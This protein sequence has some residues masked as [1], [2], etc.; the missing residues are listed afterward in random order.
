MSKNLNQSAWEILF[1]RYKI[2]KEIEKNGI[3]YISANQIKKER[4]PRLMAK[5]DHTTNLP[6]IFAQNKLSILPITRGDYAIAHFDAYH[7]FESD[8]DNEINQVSMPS[9]IQ[10]IDSNNITSE[11]IALNC[12]TATGIIADFTEDFDIIPTVSGR[13]KSGNFNFNIKDVITNKSLN[14]G[15][16]NS[17][18]EIDAAYEGVN[19]LSLIEAKIDI[20]DD[21]LIRQLYFPY[22]TWKD[23]IAKPIKPIFLVYSNGI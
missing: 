7:E 9:Y 17:Q 4:E 10:S 18:I 13:M 11:T 2:I 3:F 5:F 8:N 20:S 6:P 23:K 22:R 1:E 12:A 14:V 19:Y 21:F 16:Q 15:V